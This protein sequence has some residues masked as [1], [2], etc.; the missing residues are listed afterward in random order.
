MSTQPVREAGARERAALHRWYTFVAQS[1]AE[2]TDDVAGLIGT[3]EAALDRA[4]YDTRQDAIVWGALKRTITD[5][6]SMDLGSARGV[7]CT[8][9]KCATCGAVEGGYH[10]QGARCT[11]ALVRGDHKVARALVFGGD[12][13]R[14][15]GAL[16]TVLLEQEIRRVND[17]VAHFE[18]RSKLDDEDRDTLDFYRRLGQAL[19]NM[20]RPIDS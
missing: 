18:H 20:R 7:L 11:E 17:R 1:A 12:G 13:D 2:S 9:K 10:P 3:F 8:V 16:H 5:I 14:R 4:T 15:W 6:E 19:I